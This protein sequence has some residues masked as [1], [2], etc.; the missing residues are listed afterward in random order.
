MAITVEQHAQK[1]MALMNAGKFAQAAKAARAAF[2][3]FPRE[4]NFANVAGMALAQNGNIREALP[5]FN[6][7]LKLKPGDVGIQDNLVQAM[8]MNGQID[9]ALDLIDRLAPKRANPAQLL[10][11][12]ATA[13][14]QQGKLEE[15]VEAAT[16]SIEANPQSPLS[17]N[18]RGIANADLGRDAE[19]V[20]D[21]ETSHELNPQDPD[22]L[23]NIGNPLSRLNRFDDALAAA[24]KALALRP[25]HLN[26]LFRYA[27]LLTE[28]GEL[29]EAVEQYRKII[30]IDPLHGEAYFELVQAQSAADNAALEPQLKS[31]MAKLP[32]KA[33]PQIHLNFAMGNMHYQNGNFEQADRFLKQA[34][35]LTSEQH[36]YDKEGAE[37][38]FQRICD[39][40][41]VGC[42]PSGE[43]DQTRPRPIFVVGQPRTGTTLTE[44]ILTAHS[45]VHS[46]GEL[47]A[48]GRLTKPILQDDKPFDPLAFASEFRS[49]LPEIEEG[50]EAFVDKMPANYRFVGFLLQAFPEAS[51]I[52][53]TRDPRD[54]ALSMW[55]RYFPAEWMNFTYDLKGMAFNANLYKK[56]MAHW[57]AVYGDRILTLDYREIVSDV[58]GSA[59][60]LAKHCGLDFVEEMAA[61]ERNKAKV[62]TASLVQVR[63]GVHQK[64]LGGWR[65]MENTLAPFCDALDPALWPELG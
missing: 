56:Y 54:V 50:T 26:A 51:I 37:Q 19:A 1:V 61:P 9:K 32:Q 29:Q 20:A 43:G 2:K 36:P 11:L 30:E 25:D 60:R 22:P 63:Q 15:A 58:E 5:M 17:Y 59:K 4:G 10:Y 34:N 46:C 52:H 64:S 3:K 39:M 42:A 44:M 7:A 24:R 65:V 53:L 31:A 35:A 13:M 6:K 16:L 12:K 18:M 33:G 28:A 48:A 41:P 55:L 27:L 40:F 49:F 8:V 62:K 57:E 47:P 45:N 38:E 21:F 14:L 23:A